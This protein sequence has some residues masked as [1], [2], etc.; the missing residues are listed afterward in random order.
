LSF[1][2]DTSLVVAALIPESDSVRADAWLRANASTNLGIS[3]WVIAEFSSALSI[4]VRARQIEPSA[5]ANAMAVFMRLSM[6]AFTVLPISNEHVR[7]AARFV[8]Q[9]SRA[10]RAP[11]ALHLAICA[12]HGAALCTLDQDM[13]EAAKALGISAAEI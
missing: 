9:S 5:R 11:D 8:E 4:K 6:E 7:T 13:K 12:D 2:L 10:L 1:Y 3:E